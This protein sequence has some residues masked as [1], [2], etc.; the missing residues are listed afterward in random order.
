MDI[1]QVFKGFSK[2]KLHQRFQRLLDAGVMDAQEVQFLKKGGID[3][4]DLADHFIEN[5]IG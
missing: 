5:S 4:I 2:L 3:S 1:E